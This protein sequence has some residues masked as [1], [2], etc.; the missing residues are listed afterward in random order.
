MLVYLAAPLVLGII[1][2]IFWKLMGIV[3]KKRFGKIYKRN[4]VATLLILIYLFYPLVT[5]AAF[6]GFKCIEIEEN[7]VLLNDFSVE[8]WSSDHL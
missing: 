1:V 3:M 2:I 4:G 5:T 8:C 6:Q 7:K